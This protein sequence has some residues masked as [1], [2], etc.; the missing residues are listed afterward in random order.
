M[1]AAS[2][3]GRRLRVP[4]R[5]SC[6]NSVI[7]PSVLS[8]QSFFTA[9][10]PARLRWYGSGP[11]LGPPLQRHPPQLTHARHHRVFRFVRCIQL[12]S[13]ILHFI[14]QALHLRAQARVLRQAFLQL[15]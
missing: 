3:R 12:S 7:G 2:H 11:L 1:R 14:Q 8:Q 4:S 10:A 9:P 13:S 5:Q 15:S 6:S